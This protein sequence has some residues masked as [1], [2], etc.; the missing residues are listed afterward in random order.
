MSEVS[1][2]HTYVQN[3]NGLT[4]TSFVEG[5]KGLALGVS[6]SL[7]KAPGTNPEQFI[8]FALATCFN[9]TIRLVEAREKTAEDSALRVRVDIVK[10]DPGYKFLVTALIAMPEHERQDA[11]RIIAVALD[12]CPVAKLLKDNENVVFRLV[13]DLNAEPVLGE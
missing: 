2:Y 5:D 1:L 12:E 11:E 6:S 4:G 13:D 8:G 10:D 3:H 9:A 7:I